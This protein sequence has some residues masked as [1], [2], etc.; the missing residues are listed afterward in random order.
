MVPYQRAAPT[1]LVLTRPAEKRD[2]KLRAS[3]RGRPLTRDVSGLLRGARRVGFA[4]GLPGLGLRLV[5]GSL[6]VVLA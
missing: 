3:P 5:V 6:R 4:L 1:S 2:G